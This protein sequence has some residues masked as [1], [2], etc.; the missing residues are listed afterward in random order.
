MGSFCSLILFVIVCA[1]A[2]I[3]TDV[4][5]LKKDVTIL[6]STHKN[7]YDSDFIFD[8]DQGL[9]FAIAF[10]SFDSEMEEILDPSYGRIVYKRFGWGIK[11]NGDPWYEFEEIKSHNCSKEELGLEGDQSNFMPIDPTAVELVS[12][13]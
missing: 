3:K 12:L 10:T 4:L 6:T 13:Y 9:N 11:E 7:Y 8:F 2:Y 5:L 1:F